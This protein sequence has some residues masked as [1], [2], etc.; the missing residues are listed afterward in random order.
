MRFSCDSCGSRYLL[1]DE[2]VLGRLV[3]VRCRG[4]AALITLR[5]GAPEPPKPARLWFA[6][7]A[8]EQRGP[9]SDEALQREVDEGRVL[10]STFVWHEGM[11]EWKRLSD[12]PR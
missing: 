2:K 10:S 4:C 7:V 6:L 5:D 9:L 3:Q 12:V 1:A 11:A 8:G